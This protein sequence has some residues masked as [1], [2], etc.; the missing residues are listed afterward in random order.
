M[1]VHTPPAAVSPFR[2]VGEDVH[3]GKPT[4]SVVMISPRRMRLSIWTPKDWLR[5]PEALRPGGA[6]EIADGTWLLAE[7]ED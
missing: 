2:L 7:I 1:H 4:G 5:T 3:L 6:V